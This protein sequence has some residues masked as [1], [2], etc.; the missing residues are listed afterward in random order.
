MC[1][2]IGRVKVNKTN[3]SMIK[4][5]MLLIIIKY[6]KI[7]ANLNYFTTFC[8]ASWSRQHF[9]GTGVEKSKHNL[10]IWLVYLRN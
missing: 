8:E 2:G 10:K 5:V 1:D 9:Y 3:K 6:F 7:M 4:N